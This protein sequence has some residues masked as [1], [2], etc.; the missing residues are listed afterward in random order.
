MSA[1]IGDFLILEIL[2]KEWRIKSW[3]LLRGLFLGDFG[4][5][6]VYMTEVIAVV[7][8]L[9]EGSTTYFTNEGF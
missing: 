2:N 9:S 6:F 3:N 4:L 1:I 8:L 7:H 5:S